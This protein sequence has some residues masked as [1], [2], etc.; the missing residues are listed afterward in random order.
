MGLVNNK[1]QLQLS[2]GKTYEESIKLDVIEADVLSIIN[3]TILHELFNIS[4]IE[5]KIFM[6][7][8]TNKLITTVQQFIKNKITKEEWTMFYDIIYILDMFHELYFFMPTTLNYTIRPDISGF[9]YNIL[10]NNSEIAKCKDY[11]IFLRHL[12]N[13]YL[14]NETL[15]IE[16][17][18]NEN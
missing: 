3:Y 1:K 6:R 9:L 13:C 4:D 14:L 15:F 7:D 11:D 10:S 2:R 5:Y 8:Q 16:V 12:H 17:L 18:K